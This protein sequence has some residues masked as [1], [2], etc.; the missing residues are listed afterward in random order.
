MISVVL[1]HVLESYSF[2]SARV[3]L[4]QD[5]MDRH[6]KLLA[7]EHVRF[8]SSMPGLSQQPDTRLA[9]FAACLK[10]SGL[11]P[12]VAALNSKEPDVGTMLSSMH[13]AR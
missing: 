9:Q 6:V 12:V 11:A 4:L 1:Q 13:V 3:A 8:P 2:T 7:D 5:Q 10:Q